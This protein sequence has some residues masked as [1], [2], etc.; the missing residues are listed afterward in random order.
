M[1]QIFEEFKVKA[2]IMKPLIAKIYSNE[3]SKKFIDS[4]KIFLGFFYTFIYKDFVMRE[5]IF[6]YKQ[7]KETFPPISTEYINKMET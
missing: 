6:K 7:L 2:Q 3:S 5:I 1:A 4:E